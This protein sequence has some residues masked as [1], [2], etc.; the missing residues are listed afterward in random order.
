M[1]LIDD[2]RTAVRS[3]LCGLLNGIEA[4]DRFGINAGLPEDAPPSFPGS[5]LGNIVN[6]A[7]GLLCDRMPQSRGPS[8][9]GGQ[10]P[11]TYTVVHT[12]TNTNTSTGFVIDSQDTNTSVAGPISS[13]RIT[14]SASP[15]QITAFGPNGAQ[16]IFSNSAATVISNLRINSVTRNDGQP[17]NCLP[18]TP[19]PLPEADRTR[20]ITINNISGTVVFAVP[21]LNVNGD[22]QVG[23]TLAVGELNLSGTV[24]LNT[25]DIEFNFGGQPTDPD[26]PEVP[27][28]DVTPPDAEDDDPENEKK[29]N[30]IGVIVVATEIGT[31]AATEV[32]MLSMPNLFIPRIAN[33]SFQIRIKNRSHWTSDLPV[34]S[35]NAYIACPG[36]IDAIDVVCEPQPGWLVSAT[37]VRGIVPS[38]QVVLV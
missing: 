16:I 31:N 36:D 35:R 15:G 34:K 32:P 18:P 20:P 21:I 30:I 14:S 27:T 9:T 12:R 38:N 26:A 3:G 8:F 28:P 23:F 10:C 22:L 33:V 5:P 29:A 4:I 11:T 13:I 1:A 7:Q 37:P 25:G 19:I 24:Q 2:V 17:D 6:N